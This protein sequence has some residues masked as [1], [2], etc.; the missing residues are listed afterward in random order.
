MRKKKEK[1]AVKALSP[2]D[3]NARILG[4]D[5]SLSSTG[6]ALIDLWGELVMSESTDCKL[7][8]PAR[9]S[10]FYDFF[11][12]RLRQDNI[13]LLVV[14]GYSYGSPFNR[15]ALA[16]LGGIF[17][18]AAF[19]SHIPLLVV[20]PPT[21]RKFILPA[22][23][24]QGGKGVT[25]LHSFK[26]W[27]VEFKNDDECDAHALAQLGLARLRVD[28]GVAEGIPARQKEAAST[29]SLLLEGFK[30]PSNRVRRR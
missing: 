8:G 23:A 17:R 16:E 18:M 28:T 15:E 22:D 20:S 9:L 27:G 11:V 24:K 10:W 2:L 3:H 25:A 14:E 21:L 13:G 1:E 5:L 7:T 12:E 4:I 19:R 26:R 6:M 30:L 29:A